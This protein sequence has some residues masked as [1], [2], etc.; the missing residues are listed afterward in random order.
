[1][2]VRLRSKINI[3]VS[4]ALTV[5]SSSTIQFGNYGYDYYL[6]GYLDLSVFESGDE[7]T[8]TLNI[9]ND[10]GTTWKQ[11]GSISFT[12]PVDDPILFFSQSFYPSDV[13]VQLS[14]LQSSGTAKTLTG[15]FTA[16]TVEVL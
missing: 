13:L 2:V 12:A 7:V 14:V 16:F 6:Q 4:L 5:G 3:P 9:S 8:I 15:E 11:Y 10:G 1:M